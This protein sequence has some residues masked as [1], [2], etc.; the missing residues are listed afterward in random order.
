MFDDLR[1]LYAFLRREEHEISGKMP[2]VSELLTFD[3]QKDLATYLSLFA[4]CLS[5]RLR[6]KIHIF[7]MNLSNTLQNTIYKALIQG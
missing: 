4:T 5:S 3:E 1:K 6:G 7:D 2:L